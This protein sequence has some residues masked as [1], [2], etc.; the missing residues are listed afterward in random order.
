MTNTTSKRGF[1]HRINTWLAEPAGELF[2]N[3]KW[4]FWFP[5]LIGLSL[6]NAILTAVVFGTGGNLQTYMGSVLVGVG[7]LLAWLGVGA[8]HY[9]DANDPKLARGVSALDSVTLIFVIAHFCFLLWVYGR[10]STLKTAEANYKVAAEKYNADAREIQAGNAKIAD[11]LRAVSENETKRARIENDTIYQA[12]K[13]AQAGA[14]VD[15][16][17]REQQ[18]TGA[19]LSTSPIELAKPEKPKESSAD[20]MTYWDAWVRLANFCELALAAVTLIFIRNRSATA[21]TISG[22]RPDAGEMRKAQDVAG[23]LGNDFPDELPELDAGDVGKRS[24]IR[25]GDLTV[26]QA[27]NVRR[28]ARVLGQDAVQKKTRD[29]LANGLAA[30]RET[31]SDISFYHPNTSFKAYI[32]PDAPKAP[33]HVLVRAMLARDGT[34]ETTHSAKLKLSVLNDAVRMPREEFRAR[35][36]RSLNRAGFQLT[37]DRT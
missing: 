23:D 4:R 26:T 37:E 16:R 2:K 5:V 29:D 10:I 20:F 31:L 22:T 6:L 3:N 33:D 8:L 15:T 1:G 7:A 12:R 34:Q 13:A 32:K 36:T 21:N 25:R 17:K 27:K 18:S 35:L 19:S 11:A 28:S 30:L 9:S 24:A 14:K